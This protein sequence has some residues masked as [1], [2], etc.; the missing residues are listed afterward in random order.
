MVKRHTKPQQLPPTLPEAND[1]IKQNY[2]KLSN[3]E[4]AQQTSLSINAVEHRLRRLGLKRENKF[5]A[6]LLQ[7]GFDGE[8]WS[9]GWLKTEAVSVFI[10]NEKG[11]MSY[12][13]IR[14]ELISE[15]KRYAPKYPRIARKDIKDGHLLIIDPAD[16]HIGKLSLIEETSDEY[17]IEIAKKRC[18]DGVLGIIEKAKG[19]P[20]EKIVFVIG[21]D[22]LHTDNPFSSTTAGTKQDVSTQWWKMFTEA[23]DLYIRIIETLL[24]IANVHVVF[25]PSNHDYVSGFMLADTIASW[26]HNNKH[27]TFDGRIV[28]RKYM[29]YGKNLLAFSHGDGAKERDVKDLMA[30]EVP[31]LWGSTKFRYVYLHH[32]HHKKKVNWLSGK[33]Y[34]GVT[35]EY[36]RSPS[37]SDS[38]H[39][40]NGYIAQKAVEGFIHHKDQGQCARLTHYF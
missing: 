13:D 12:E 23:K 10:K 14:D 11:F 16:V 38:W 26:F 18:I 29:Q 4:L 3:S 27:V 32:I 34:I 8:N 17:N 15:M 24:P 35:V 22:I 25:C 1:F 28:H 19:Y 39:F 9:H 5:N 2:Q 30:D 21:N 6:D 37:S 33:D 7:N 31:K 20:I 36:L 40:R